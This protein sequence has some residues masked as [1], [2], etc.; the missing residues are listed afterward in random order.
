MN[1]YSKRQETRASVDQE[2]AARETELSPVQANRSKAS[3]LGAPSRSRLAT[4]GGC[5]LSS[6]NPW[7]F[8]HSNNTT[9]ITLRSACAA[10]YRY[11]TSKPC[12][13][14]SPV[15]VDLSLWRG[16]WPVLT[17][18]RVVSRLD[19]V[20]QLWPVRSAF[21][22][23]SSIGF[24]SVSKSAFCRLSPVVCLC[25]YRHARP[26]GSPN[27]SPAPRLSPV[28]SAPPR[29]KGGPINSKESKGKRATHSLPPRRISH[30]DTPSLISLIPCPKP[31]TPPHCSPAH[32]TSKPPPSR[33]H[34]PVLHSVVPQEDFSS[35]CALH[36]PSQKARAA[37]GEKQ[38]A[39]V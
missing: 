5:S 30:K 3:L 32:A 34:P 7:D 13:S 8:G 15:T 29:P 4:V 31:P 11:C 28:A 12:Q 33:R 27:P 2:Q 37:A 14:P 35:Q 19:P 21:H 16:Y 1:P 20:W 38:V 9:D 6:P 39:T 24:L 18:W 23:T 10:P 25:Y 22:P 36:L 26:P 17:L